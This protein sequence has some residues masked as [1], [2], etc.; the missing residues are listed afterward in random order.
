MGEERQKGGRKTE[1]Q[2]GNMAQCL[3]FSLLRLLLSVLSLTTL[4][5]HLSLRQFSF[6][7]APL[8]VRSRSCLFPQSHISFLSFLLLPPLISRSPP[9]PPVPLLP[10]H[11]PLDLKLAG[12]CRDFPSL[13]CLLPFLLYSSRFEERERNKTDEYEERVRARARA[14]KHTL[15]LSN[16]GRLPAHKQAAGRD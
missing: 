7:L 6:F 4:S 11:L 16:S 1:G 3:C 2:G 12:T 13:V 9:D 5:R 8:S 10:R 14:S 15:R